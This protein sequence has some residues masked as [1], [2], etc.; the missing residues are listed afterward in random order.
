MYLSRFPWRAAA[1][2]AAAAAPDFAAAAV[3]PHPTP[4][5]LGGDTFRYFWLAIQSTANWHVSNAFVVPKK[6][7]PVVGC[8]HVRSGRDRLFVP[9]G[10]R[11][12]SEHT[13]RTT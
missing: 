1:A 8:G 10:T 13:T 7:S 5:F 9:C 6:K 2:A 3:R 4:P 11:R 12:F